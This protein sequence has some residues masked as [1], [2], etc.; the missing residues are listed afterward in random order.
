LVEVLVVIAI[1]GLL[2][3]LLLPTVQQVREAAYRTQSRNN[4]KQI[5]LAM[6]HYAGAHQGP[7][8][9]FLMVDPDPSQSA[10]GIWPPSVFFSF[11]PYVEQGNQMNFLKES[12]QQGQRPILISPYVSPA[13]PTVPRAI[14]ARVSA[15]PSY[16]ANAQVFKNDPLLSTIFSDG[17]SNTI[18][19]AEHYADCNGIFFSPLYSGVNAFIASPR[20]ATFAD[21]GDVRPITRGSPPVSYSNSLIAWEKLFQVAPSFEKCDPRLPQTPHP[22]GML[23][24]L[25]DGSVRVLSAG[26]SEET[27]WGAVTPRGG[28][29]LGS[30]WEE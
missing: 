9:G 18:A 25:G 30:D 11:L 17:A 10:I 15:V 12:L 27:F 22:A 4:L 28:E 26:M 2:I 24:A 7:L 14:T 8:S 23:A 20:R 6:H 3:A 5:A 29:I 16:A 13:D 19:F 21:R 1:I